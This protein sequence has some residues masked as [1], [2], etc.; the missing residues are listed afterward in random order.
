MSAETGSAALR[1]RPNAAAA[2]CH[3][4]ALVEGPRARRRP[5]C[6]QH[7]PNPMR[8]C[9]HG[10]LYYARKGRTAQGRHAWKPAVLLV[11]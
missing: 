2:C 10:L 7:F 11:C 4:I 3:R 5:S 1:C 8:W 6:K 9:S